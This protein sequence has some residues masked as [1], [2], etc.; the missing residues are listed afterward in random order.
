MAQIYLF[1]QCLRATYFRHL[2]F[3][4]KIFLIPLENCYPIKLPNLFFPQTNL[5]KSG[6]FW[7]HESRMFDYIIFVIPTAFIKLKNH[8][9]AVNRTPGFWLKFLKLNQ[10]KQAL[11]KLT[12]PNCTKLD[13]SS[14]NKTKLTT[15]MI[16]T[17]KAQKM[18]TRFFNTGNFLSRYVFVIT[19]D[20]AGPSDQCGAPP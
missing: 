8:K 3:Q 11:T 19:V 6:N 17:G 10:K 7:K 14:L 5:M 18:W 1:T 16:Q 9:V 20:A 12:K 4:C 2:H 13:R 15:E